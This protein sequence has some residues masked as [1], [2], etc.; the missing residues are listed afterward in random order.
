MYKTEK[1]VI[2]DMIVSESCPGG[3]HIFTGG[4]SKLELP[5]TISFKSEGEYKV[6]INSGR[7]TVEKIY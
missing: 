3:K 4:E 7:V 5:Y 2:E 6:C 1:K